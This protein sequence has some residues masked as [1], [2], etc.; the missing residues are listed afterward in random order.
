ML[1]IRERD[2]F[3]RRSFPRTRVHRFPKG[4]VAPGAPARL[5]GPDDRELPVQVDAADLHDDGSVRDGEITFAPTLGAGESRAY[6]LELGGNS[7]AA[8]VRNPVSAALTDEGATITQGVIAY[9]VRSTGYNLVDTAIFRDRPFLH[10]G[11]P[12]PV[13]V[14]PSGPPVAPATARIAVERNGPWMV[15]LRIDGAC[16][17]GRPFRSRLEFVSSKSWFSVHHDVD[18]RPDE[19]LWLEARLALGPNLSSAFGSRPCAAGDHTSWSVVTDGAFTVDIGAASSPASAARVRHEVSPE[20][21][22]RLC[23]P[24]GD[25]RAVAWFHYLHGPPDD[26]VNTPA[27]AMAAGL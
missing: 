19:A 4:A 5:L 8:A 26:V 18:A 1:D 12:G 17:D 13:L 25:D 14:G 10:P 22:F 3:A 15:R 11:S 24:T 6:R 21:L 7:P 9:T 16:T 27:A 23:L 20:G 2:G